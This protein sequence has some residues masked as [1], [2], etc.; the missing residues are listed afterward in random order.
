VQL[1]CLMR[2]ATIVMCLLNLRGDVRTSDSDVRSAVLTI[3][4]TC[5]D[6][7]L[8]RIRSF[9]KPSRVSSRLVLHRDMVVYP[10]AASTHTL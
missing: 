8:S 5:S 10:S 1:Y 3:R 2:D 7:S 9:H 6:M 4:Y